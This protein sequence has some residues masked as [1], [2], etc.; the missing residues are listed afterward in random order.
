MKK[1]TV[2]SVVLFSVFLAASCATKSPAVITVEVAEEAATDDEFTQEEANEAF[3]NAYFKYR[4]LLIL[5][6]AGTYRVVRGDTLGGIARTNY[7]G[8]NGY[9]Y[10]LIM[11]ASSDNVQVQDP[12]LIEPGME[13]TI[14]NLQKNLDEPSAKSALKAFLAEV[15]KIYEQKEKYNDRDALQALSDSL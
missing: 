4:G 11:L 9:F 13:L 14:P 10:P 6:G 2:V 5:D 3:A 1:C 15:A 7:Q 8:K 12:D